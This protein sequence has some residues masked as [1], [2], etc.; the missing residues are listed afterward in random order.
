MA[1]IS[2]IEPYTAHMTRQLSSKSSPWG[3]V[4][5]RLW[6]EQEEDIFSTIEQM[7]RDMSRFVNNF[8]A[9]DLDERV[10]RDELAEFR[11]WKEAKREE[12]KAQINS[13]ETREPKVEA[14]E[15][16]E[17]RGNNFFQKFSSVSHTHR[18][19]H[20]RLVTEIK[21]DY[22]DSTGLQ[23]SILRR[24]LDD[25]AVTRIKSSGAEKEAKEKDVSSGVSVRLEGLDET[26][27]D[28]FEKE[29]EKIQKKLYDS[30]NLWKRAIEL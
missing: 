27:V 3:A 16:P 5:R 30:K 2:R 8:S 10:S 6:R 20:G 23:K 17:L 13:K 24:A 29:W 12:Q 7:H 4:S 18:D 21:K 14:Q 26:G 19:E 11:R 25:K 1:F 28:E 22:E 9:W 15:E